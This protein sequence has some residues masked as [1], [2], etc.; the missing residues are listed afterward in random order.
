M[1]TQRPCCGRKNT[2]P[3][4][5]TSHQACKVL[6]KID[7]SPRTPQRGLCT[8]NETFQDCTCCKVYNHR[9]NGRRCRDCLGETWSGWVWTCT[10]SI[11]P[12]CM[13]CRGRLSIF[14]WMRVGLELDGQM[15]QT[16]EEAGLQQGLWCTC[17][18]LICCGRQNLDNEQHNRLSF[19]CRWNSKT[20]NQQLSTKQRR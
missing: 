4:V 20:I 14:G 11:K 5:C 17:A 12:S 13:D 18:T 6:S 16:A 9:R 10:S 15:K 19:R 8:K 2:F 1:R 7:M 3:R